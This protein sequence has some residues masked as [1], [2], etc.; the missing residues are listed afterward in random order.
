MK[1]IIPNHKFTYITFF[2]LFV[3]LE[4]LFWGLMGTKPWKENNLPWWVNIIYTVVALGLMLTGVLI[5]RSKVYYMV[6]NKG[7]YRHGKKIVEY[8]FKDIVYLDEEYANNHIETKIYLS[9]GVWVLLTLDRKKELL[10][11][12]K[13]KSP[14][15]DKENFIY[16][17]PNAFNQIKK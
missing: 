9:T 5:Y 10:K 17:Y 7:I 13:D 8:R 3:A 1:K 15:L 6:D 11:L 4:F 14:L 2:V 12:I 16:K